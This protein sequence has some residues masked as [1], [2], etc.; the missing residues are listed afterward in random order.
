MNVELEK[1]SILF[2]NLNEKVIQVNFLGLYPVIQV[3]SNSLA[4][5]LTAQGLS[6]D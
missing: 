1:S 3:N 5:G 6:K 2:Y 4:S